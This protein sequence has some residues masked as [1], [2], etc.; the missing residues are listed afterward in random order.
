MLYVV[1]N[2]YCFAGS[3]CDSEPMTLEK[4]EDILRNIE[5]NIRMGLWDKNVSC[6]IKPVNKIK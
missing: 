1:T 3:Y 2:S 4:A 6:V 5:R